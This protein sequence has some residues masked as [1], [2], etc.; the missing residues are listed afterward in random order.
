[1][2][3][4]RKRTRHSFG[5]RWTDQERSRL[6]NLRNSHRK[7]P[8]EVFRVNYFPNRSI[9]AL[10]KQ[11]SDI[12]LSLKRLNAM[13]LGELSNG[14]NHPS[15]TSA[16]LGKRTT[17]DNDPATAEPLSKQTRISEPDTEYSPPESEDSSSSDDDDGDVQ[18]D[19]SRAPR[20]SPRKQLNRPS[21]L[22]RLPLT[23][24]ERPHSSTTA[25]VADEQPEIPSTSAS[26]PVAFPQ[27]SRAASPQAEEQPE[28]M[29]SPLR[30]LNTDKEPQRDKRSLSTSPG[31]REA[32][33]D[34]LGKV[35]QGFIQSREEHMRARHK[36]EALVEQLKKAL[37]SEKGEVSHLKDLLEQRGVEVNQ[38]KEFVERTEK[39]AAE[40]KAQIVRL[41]A[42]LQGQ[43]ARMG[44]IPLNDPDSARPCPGCTEKE[45]QIAEKEQ[46]IDMIFKLFGRKRSTVTPIPEAVVP[47]SG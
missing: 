36:A 19:G 25:A 16:R 5:G 29:K 46:K 6:W 33:C 35:V 47:D 44:Q 14:N 15:R 2:P 28:M 20:R 39:I 27:A 40:R 13:D 4:I 11:Y 43:Q 23:R 1:M 9:N 41:T 26:N 31:S 12:R 18:M 32:S 22:V 21:R 38:L 30:P 45:Q 8:W 3:S 24:T 17:A 37:R 7:L 10:Q 34:R 42:E